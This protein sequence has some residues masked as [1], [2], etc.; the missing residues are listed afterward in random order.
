MRR[1]AAALA[2]S[3]LLFVSGG[4]RVAAGDPPAAPAAPATAPPPA[5]TPEQA[6]DAVLAAIA[7]KDEAELRALASKDD[8]D[9][10]LV[11][12]ELIRRG[13]HDAAG[14]FAEA[15]PRP[16]TERLPAYV[17]SRRG[18]PDDAAGRERLASANAAIMRRDTSA[19][20]AALGDGAAGPIRDVVGVRL[21]YGRGLLLATTPRHGEAV[22]AFVAA[23][24]AAERLGWLSRAVLAIVGA[25]S[26]ARRGASFAPAME[27]YE[28]WRALADR[29]GDRINAARAL[30]NIGSLHAVRGDYRRARE[31]LEQALVAL[32][33]AG[34]RYG[35]ATV[36]GD[37]GSVL[38]DLG[39]PALARAAQE[40]ALAEFEALGDRAGV[41]RVLG[42]LANL[43]ALLGERE[44]ALSMTRQALQAKESIGDRWGA[45]ATRISLA[46]QLEKRGEFAVAETE[47]DRARSEAEALGDGVSVASA[48]V[49][50][51]TC[52]FSL[53]D[54]PRA[55]AAFER[56]RRGY[57]TAD[58]P[59]GAAIAL[60]NLGAVA[61]AR[62]D[63]AGALSA[64]E[65]ALSAQEA[66]GDL[67]TAASILQHVASMHRARG[68]FSAALHAFD[69]ARRALESVGDRSGVAILR[70]NMGNLRA[71]LGDT[72]GA[73]ALYSQ[74][75]EDLQATGQKVMAA[76]AL[77]AMANA[78]LRLGEHERARELLEQS[79]VVLD[80]AGAR[81]EVASAR[82]DL[83]NLHLASGEKAKSLEI[84]E[85][86][87]EE[88][89]ALGRRQLEAS[90]LLGIGRVRAALGRSAE[91]RT[92]FDAS[93]GL[94]RSLRATPQL[95]DAL[96]F[97]A[98]FHL[99][100]GD[101]AR[102]VGRAREARDAVE[103]MLGGLGDEEG[104]A[105]RSESARLYAVGALA[106]SREADA[107]ET[108][109]FLESGRAGALLESLGRRD[110]LR[111]K[112]AT[113]SEDLQ[114]AEAKSAAAEREARKAYE[115][116]LADRTS[117]RSAIAAAARALDERMDD[118]RGVQ[119]R[120]EREGKRGAGLYYPRPRTLDDVR[121]ALYDGDALVLYGLCLDEAI[122]VVATRSDARIVA[123]G[124]RAA[125]EAACEAL[126]CT[127]PG[128]DV[129][130]SLTA[131]RKAL[132]EPLGL[133]QD[134]R[135]VLVSPEGPL[136]YQPFAA[137]FSVPVAM[138]P[139]GSTHVLLRDEEGDRGEGVLA[140]GDP[141]YAGTS[142]GA[143][144]IL[145]RGRPLSPLPATRPEAE[146]IGT[147]TLLGPKATEEGLR[148]ALASRGRWRAVHLACHGLIDPDR[149][150]LSSLALTRAGDDDGFLTALEVLRTPFSADLA[151]LSACETAKGKVVTGEGI[152][153]LTRA[154]MFAGSPRVICSLWKVD[155]EATS[156]LMMKFYE[157]WNPKAGAQG[158]NSA[159]A[160][161]QAQDFVRSHEK[162]KHPYF[163]AAWVLWGL[164]T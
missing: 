103:S 45:V 39:E 153:G 10:W 9:P 64:F 115:R 160:L 131:L 51:G 18:Q 93:V 33:S 125:L 135:R 107:A 82:E 84:L 141:D 2:L 91:A 128:A 62:G 81:A 68:D 163:W 85:R 43:Y 44:G 61:A 90:V 71:D 76:R 152:V 4:A 77:S 119:T 55:R 147:T 67:R 112:A 41:A 20:L 157:L 134:V 154:F 23:A 123:L 50:V 86:V 6:S 15:S 17:A 149:P 105:A 100:A 101:V 46:G 14:A 3:V 80:A 97:L 34:D 140:L 26:A 155:D 122:A 48:W 30:S 69:R 146:A 116:V 53:G 73:L 144:R 94:A 42:N 158:L 136:G 98:E 156:A 113:L 12:D 99:R 13:Q 121:A 65:R 96:K 145:L 37:L 117:D 29:R 27:A 47:Y 102:A 54:Y 25:G 143:Q 92:A 19:G 114:D 132:V 110:L 40:R 87:L 58:N 49:G 118:R 159:D 104:A 129:G 63:F 16:D 72:E 28:R 162:W 142:E 106:A 164:P 161:R 8:P 11:A 78:S 21:A 22:A 126:D 95:A 130:P 124:G 1:L 36:R 75:H 57:E 88:A 139:S 60:A 38:V 56:G 138:T 89:R 137:L 66:L 59:V 109:A 111:W 70:I 120:I 150:T 79:L 52:A 151:V 108:A 127:D 31:V 5:K 24:D 35:S 83:A 7:A 133:G 74:A 32:E 148:R